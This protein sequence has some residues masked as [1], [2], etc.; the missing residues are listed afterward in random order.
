MS[1]QSSYSTEVRMP[2][3]Y[4]NNISV[5]STIE[6]IREEICLKILLKAIELTSEDLRGT[7]VDT[8]VDFDGKE[9]KC[10]MGIKTKEYSRGVG[11]NIENGKVIFIY[12]AYGDGDKW[13]KLIGS[14]VNQNYQTIAVMKAQE[15]LGYKVQVH[16]TGKVKLVVG[17][18]SQNP[19]HLINI[20]E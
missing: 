7:I 15:D 6:D 14:S 19:L 11:I 17:R 8:I 3:S 5:I 9:R 13:G 18:L 10:L 4:A 12:D 16:D 1:E 20:Y 2:I